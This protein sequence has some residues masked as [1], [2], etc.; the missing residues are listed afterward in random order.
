MKHYLHTADEVL[1]SVGSTAQGLT[2]HEAA[3][4]LEKNGLNKLDEAKARL[5]RFEIELAEMEPSI[6]NVFDL[7]LYIKFMRERFGIKMTKYFQ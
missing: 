3:Q 2:D 5:D 1:K 7:F 6:H 4:R